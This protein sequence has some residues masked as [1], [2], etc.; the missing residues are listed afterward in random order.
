MARRLRV[1]DIFRDSQEYLLARA[2][3][4]EASA[5]FKR[6]SAPIRKYLDKNGIE[7]DD[8]NFVYEFPKPLASV[9]GEEYSGVML[10]KG[11]QE[12]YFDIGEVKALLKGKICPD[13][14]AAHYKV[15]QHVEVL[16][17][18][19][20]YALQQED[21]ITEEE[22]RGLIHYTKPSYSLWPV[23]ATEPLEDDE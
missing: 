12:P 8:G 22:L 11:K 19:A 21:I 23:K 10:K 9:D 1:P 6:A 13:G 20:L 2:Q 7:D 17:Q 3:N 15:I 4:S 14:E 16:D 18:D 5:A